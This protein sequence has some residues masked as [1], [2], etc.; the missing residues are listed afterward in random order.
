M[1]RSKSEV[2][3]HR[4]GHDHSSSLEP[5]SGREKGR[6][7]ISTVRRENEPQG[8]AR[9]RFEQ[10]ALA[11]SKWYSVMSLFPSA[12]SNPA[13]PKELYSM[14]GTKQLGMVSPNSW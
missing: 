8:H 3:G 13:T 2:I 4:D 5:R 1:A 14:A 11:L 10:A 6:S 7:L 12:R 9:K